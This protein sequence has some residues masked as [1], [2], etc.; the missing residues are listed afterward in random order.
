LRTALDAAG[1]ATLAYLGAF[2]LDGVVLTATWAGA[3]FAL[4]LACSRVGYAPGR[5]GAAAFVGLALVHVLI[6]EAPPDSLVYGVDDAVA[7]FVAIAVVA[8]AAIGCS[9]LRVSADPRWKLSFEVLGG[10]LLIYLGSVA[11]VNAF[12]PDA[13]FDTGLDL[14]I[15]Q[16]GQAILS[17]FWSV[18]GLAA[19]VYGLIR[20][21]RALR[22]SGFTL[23]A[24]AVTKVFLYD[25]ATLESLWRVLS[26]VALGLLLLAGA[27][28][29][30]RMQPSEASDLARR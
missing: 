24:L 20:N 17:A 18:A 2:A 22:L 11:I 25:L 16:Q 27:L 4:A 9:Q 8:M 12:Q 14:E 15:R 26:F 1:L 3:A 29:Y 13:A 5:F 19:L 28:A 7:A 6:Y 21:S 30:Q 23:L 10:A